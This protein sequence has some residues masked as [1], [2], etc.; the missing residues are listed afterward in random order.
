MPTTSSSISSSEAG[1][2]ARLWRGFVL[3]FAAT[4]AIVFATLAASLVVLDP[5]D[6]GRFALLKAQGVPAQAPRT[7][8]ASRGRDPAFEAAILGNS[9]IQILSPEELTRQTG[10]PFVSLAV[11]GTGPRETFALLDYFLRNRTKP[12]RALVLG[13]DPPW[14]RSE[15]DMPTWLPF[16]FWLY[17][18]SPWRYLAGIV[19]MGS[20]EDAF[21]RLAFAFRPSKR[22]R[23]DGYWDYDEGFVWQKERHG[24]LFA[25]PAPSGVRN[26]TGRFPAIDA[27]GR[28]LDRLPPDLPVILV[29]PPVHRTALAEPGSALARSEEACRT[30][31]SRMAEGRRSVALLDWRVDRPEIHIDGNFIDPTHY[32]RPIA[33]A[34][35]RDV[36]AAILESAKVPGG[37]PWR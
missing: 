37:K 17:E 18:R 13:I 32:R 16:P 7:A 12:A 23:P 5:Y 26:E 3:A 36:A 21:R 30:A 2:G 29:R 8:H 11:P 27:L 28:E 1:E 14:C 34:L 19:R 4:S 25:R 33:R 24:P 9:H 22:A 20:L 6:T 31:L 10:I 15:A 35:E